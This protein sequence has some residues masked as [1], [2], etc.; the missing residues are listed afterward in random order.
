LAEREA[1]L[2]DS[3][4]E[5]LTELNK[6]RKEKRTLRKDIRIQQEKVRVASQAQLL[7]PV[8]RTS[9]TA[10]AVAALNDA[11]AT[12]LQFI[13]PDMTITMNHNPFR[14]DVSLAEGGSDPRDFSDGELARADLAFMLAYRQVCM[15]MSNV[16][17]PSSLLFID[18]RTASFS[19]AALSS[20]FE[21]I[22]RWAEATETRVF[23]IEHHYAGHVI[24][25]KLQVTKAEGVSKFT[26][27]A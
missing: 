9:V 18:E 27:V 1:K 19:P 13:D 5:V 12:I 3:V 7:L 4:D 15:A 22:A 10:E 25:S 2:E 21:S 17:T 20:V 6:L 24:D 14:L 16:K 8:I 26:W 23:F 11:L